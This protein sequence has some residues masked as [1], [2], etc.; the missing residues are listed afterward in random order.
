MDQYCHWWLAG[1]CAWAWSC[2][3][4]YFAVLRTDGFSFYP[5]FIIQFKDGTIGILETKKDMTAKRG[6]ILTESKIR[7][8]IKYYHNTGRLPLDWKY[9][10]EGAKLLV[11]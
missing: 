2:R 7:R 5:D 9:T 6:L 3:K 10:R 11:S 8:L 4:K 1:Y